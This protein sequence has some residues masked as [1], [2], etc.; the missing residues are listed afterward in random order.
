MP[1]AHKVFSLFLSS[2]QYILLWKPIRPFRVSS[3]VKLLFDLFATF[4]PMVSQ[5]YS[6]IQVNGGSQETGECM[7][8]IK[9][10]CG[11]GQMPHPL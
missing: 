7:V 10:L 11:F 1:L 5:S 9:W 2:T 3:L 6:F 8:F 4:S